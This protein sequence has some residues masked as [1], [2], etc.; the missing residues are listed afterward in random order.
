MTYLDSAQT[1]AVHSLS[2]GKIL[3][4]GVGSGKSRT[5]L[6][7]FYTKI[8]GGKLYDIPAGVTNPVDL[9]IITT[10]KKRDN[11]EWDEDMNLLGLFR[12]HGQVSVTIDSWNNI[13]KYA[14]VTNSFFI[15][16]EQRL[17]GSGSW[18]RNFY[19]IVSAQRYKHNQ[20]GNRWILCSATPGDTWTDYI[21]VFVANGFCPNKTEFLY[22][23]AVYKPMTKF[24]QIIGWRHEEKLRCWERSLLVNIEVKRS[25]HRVFKTIKVPY[26]RDK[27]KMVVDKRWDPYANGP[28]QN[29]AGYCQILRRVCNDNEHKVN[30][31][32]QLLTDNDK[33][34]IFYNFD[35]ELAVLREIVS[36]MGIPFSEW[37]GHKHQP[38]LYENDSWCYLVNYMAG[39]EGWNCIQ[40][41]VI[42][43]F[44]MNYSYRIMEQACGRIDRRNTPFSELYY[45]SIVTESSIDRAISKAVSKKQIFNE[46]KFACNINSA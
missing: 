6:A 9:Y 22:E 1:L 18:V 24:P 3:C 27:Y 13:G 38:I 44:S 5:A 36:E 17:V 43:F 40:T 11:S 29:V 28:I 2:S 4:G 41:N 46:R 21:P 35:Y 16:D 42:I 20:N 39:S 33:T 45:Y 7:Y 26:D 30:V 8:C 31:L 32:K 23:H 14:H 12:D 10:A 19:R 34:I 15:F 25:T 37:N